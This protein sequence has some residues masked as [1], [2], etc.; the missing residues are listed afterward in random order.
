[1]WELLAARTVTW[2]SVQYISKLNLAK[3]ASLIPLRQLVSF[4]AAL[5]IAFFTSFW[6]FG[7]LPTHFPLLV[8][9]LGMVNGLASYMSFRATTISQS[10]MVFSYLIDDIVAITLSMIFLREYQMVGWP[11]LAGALICILATILFAYN[12]KQKHQDKAN[13]PTKIS[14][15]FYLLSFGALGI[16]GAVH[17]MMRHVG[18]EQ[19]VTWEEFVLPWYGGTFIT[20]LIIFLLVARKQRLNREEIQE[21]FAMR[22]IFWTLLIAVPTFLNIVFT[23]WTFASTPMVIAK[24]IFSLFQVITVILLG[25]FVFG[26]RRQQNFNMTDWCAFGLSAIGV[27]TLTLDT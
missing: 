5:L 7:G 11:T 2:A 21:V 24:P 27:I 3:Q 8:M 16:W 1:M 15:L 23:F 26:E 17:F 19:G 22:N 6:L 13:A 20:A 12:N 14:T 10:A 4:S 25:A 9:V 18:F